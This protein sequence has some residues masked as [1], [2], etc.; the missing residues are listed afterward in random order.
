METLPLLLTLWGKPLVT[1][2]LAMA[3]NLEVSCLVNVN[4]MTPMYVSV[5]D[6]TKIGPQIQFSLVTFKGCSC[7]RHIRNTTA[8]YF[9]MMKLRNVNHYI[10]VRH[11]ECAGVSSHRHI[12]CLFNRLF[13]HKSKKIS[14]LRVTDHCEGNSPMTGEF[15][16]QRASKDENVSIWWIPHT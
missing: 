16:A 6:T 2:R 5:I 1:G 7:N 10:N 11:N 15:P 13:R 8:A 9:V 4:A 12:D 14:K 3:S